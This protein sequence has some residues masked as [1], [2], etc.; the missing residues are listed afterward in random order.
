MK[1]GESV[2]LHLA[3]LHGELIQRLSTTPSECWF[4]L[5]AAKKLVR[6]H[7][8][9]MQNAHAAGEPMPELPAPPVVAR[10]VTLVPVV[11]LA[12]GPAGPAPIGS[13]VPACFEHVEMPQEMPRQVGLIDVTGRP[14]ITRGG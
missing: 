5:A 14:I 4:C 3:Q 9:A 10:A 6:S 7:Q 11:Q 2:A 8:I 13:S 12:A 1:I